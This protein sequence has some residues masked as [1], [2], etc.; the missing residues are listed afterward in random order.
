MSDNALKWIMT[1]VTTYSVVLN[2]Y[3][4]DYISLISMV[5]GFLIAY[6]LKIVF[7]I[8]LR[9]AQSNLMTL[10]LANSLW[11]LILNCLGVDS[12]L[13]TYLSNLVFSCFFGLF[14]FNDDNHRGRKRLDQLKKWW[15]KQITIPG[16]MSQP[17]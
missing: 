1:A 17:A 3:Q 14:L 6:V 9:D 10:M 11:W 8:K 13:A 7:G 15:K 5:L 4:S 16:V 2:T 12:S